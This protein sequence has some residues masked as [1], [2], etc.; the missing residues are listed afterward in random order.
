MCGGGGGRG[1]GCIVCMVEPW[2]DVGY[3]IIYNVDEYIKLTVA[4]LA[5]YIN[6]AS[7]QLKLCN[8]SDTP[9]ELLIVNV[10]FYCFVGNI[11]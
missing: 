4:G 6:K 3:K 9:L 10:C 8:C 5:L 2:Q 11:R 7:F 1:G